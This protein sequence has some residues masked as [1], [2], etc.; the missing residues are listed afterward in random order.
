M[1][2]TTDPSPIFSDLGEALY[3]ISRRVLTREN[4]EF[5]VHGPASKFDRV[6]SNLEIMLRTI[7]TEN[8]S[9][10]VIIVVFM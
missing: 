2:K 3:E 10:V 5:A 6:A 7:A 1:L 4:I 9:K 8:L